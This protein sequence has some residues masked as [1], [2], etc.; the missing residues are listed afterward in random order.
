MPLKISRWKLLSAMASLELTVISLFAMALL[1]I[2]GTVLQSEKGIYFAQQKIFQ[3]WIFWLFGVLPLPGMLLIGALLFVNLLAAVV[4]RLK[5]KWSGLGLLLVHLG[6]LVL[7]GGGFISFQYGR[8][9]FITLNVGESGQM[10][11]AAHEWELAV[12]TEAGGKRQVQAVDIAALRAGRPWTLPGL[13]LDMTIGGIFSN[14]RPAAAEIPGEIA[15]IEAP[16]AADPVDNVPGI[17]LHLH[18]LPGDQRRINLFAG[19]DAP[20]VRSYLERDIYFSLRLK[21]IILPLR[22]TLLDFKKTVYSG[23]E[24]PKSFSSR[25]AVESNGLRREALI[26]MNRPLRFRGYTFYQ[27]AYADGGAH[28]PSSTFAV[29]RNVGRWLPYISSGLVFIGLA[30]HFIVQLAAV[31]IKPR[32]GVRS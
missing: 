7:L 26:A 8:E 19:S 5:I 13:D 20:V 18:G 3:S 10:A 23:T 1:V 6:L 16:P 25:V 14:C 27:S 15:L 2:G 4:F 32:S 12:W 28:G 11:D 30:L 31:L 24:I 22:L 9:Y 21:R 17:I 29:V